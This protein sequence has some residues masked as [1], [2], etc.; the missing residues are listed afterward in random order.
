MD[1]HTLIM[2]LI[3]HSQKIDTQTVITD[4]LGRRFVQCAGCG[5]LVRLGPIEKPSILGEFC[6]FECKL[7]NAR[8]YL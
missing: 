2:T 6:N 3:A 7:E 1:E 8:S 5:E 4:R